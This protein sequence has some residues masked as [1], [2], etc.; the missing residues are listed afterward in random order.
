MVDY[1]IDR[2]KLCAQE[3]TWC[4]GWLPSYCCG[5]LVCVNGTSTTARQKRQIHPKLFVDLDRTLVIAFLTRQ[6]EN[7]CATL[8]SVYLPQRNA[9]HEY[10]VL[11]SIFLQRWSLIYRSGGLVYKKYINT[12]TTKNNNKYD[13]RPSFVLALWCFVV[14]RIFKHART[15][16]QKSS[17]IHVVILKYFS[18]CNIALFILFKY[19]FHFRYVTHFLYALPECDALCFLCKRWICYFFHFR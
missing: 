6:T 18:C 1:S 3:W 7:Q 5:V 11:S 4:G 16:S 14:I 9:T 13:I 2:M 17:A 10:L 12:T 8:T 19:G 15:V